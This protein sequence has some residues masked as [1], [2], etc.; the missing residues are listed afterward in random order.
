[1]LHLP[2]CIVGEEIQAPDGS[3]Y[4]LRHSTGSA[5]FEVGLISIRNRERLVSNFK[6][7]QLLSRDNSEQVLNV[8]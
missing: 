8:I 7:A 4:M 3:G 6:L 1:M 2:L 5:L